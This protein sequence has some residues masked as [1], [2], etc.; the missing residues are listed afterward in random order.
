[1]SKEKDVDKLKSLKKR[2]SELSTQLK[3]LGSEY[4]GNGMYQSRQDFDIIVRIVECMSEE[5]DILEK[6]IEALEKA[7]K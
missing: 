4:I 2:V 5:I 7:N 1:M 3:A 6:R